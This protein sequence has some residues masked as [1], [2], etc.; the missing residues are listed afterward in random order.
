MAVVM[1]NW[2][3][4]PHLLLLFGDPLMVRS[5]CFPSACPSLFAAARRQWC[6]TVMI[7]DRGRKAYPKSGG[8]RNSYRL[9]RFVYQPT[10]YLQLLTHKVLPF[11]NLFSGVIVAI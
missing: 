11:I 1:V 6:S 10:G 5:S 7:T 9:T 4:G 2:M 8:V 3:I